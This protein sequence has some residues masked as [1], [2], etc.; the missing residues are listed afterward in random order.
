M[1][2]KTWCYAMITILLLGFVA[3]LVISYKNQIAMFLSS[4]VAP[5]GLLLHIIVW[6]L[7]ILVIGATILAMLYGASFVLKHHKTTEISDIGQ[8]GTVLVS[9][10]KHTIV[11][12]YTEKVKELKEKVQKQVEDMLP[13]PTLHDL[14]TSG[15]LLRM[16]TTCEMILGYNAD[17]ISEHT[18][19]IED[20]RTTG[21]AGKSRSGKTVTMAFLIIQY[22]LSGGKVYLID[23]AWNKASSL[24]RLLLP[25][26]ETGYIKVARKPNEIVALVDEFTT[27]LDN[28]ENDSTDMS[29]TCILVFDEWTSFM[30]DKLMVKKLVSIVHRIANESAG[31]N[32][33]ALVGGQNWQ[34]SQA[35]GNALINS[36]HSFFVHK[37]DELESKRILSRRYAKLTSTLKVG[38]NLFKDTSGDVI[39]LITP[40]TTVNDSTIAVSILQGKYYPSTRV[41]QQ[42]SSPFQYHPSFPV[43]N[44]KGIEAP[45]PDD[46]IPLAPLPP[47]MDIGAM[48]TANHPTTTLET[49]LDTKDTSPLTFDLIAPS[50]VHVTAKEQ[51]DIALAIQKAVT[52]GK[53]TKSGKVV[54][55]YVQS[56]LGY[57]NRQYEKVKFYCDRN[58]F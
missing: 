52:D 26:I 32:A 51:K 14:L 9:H 35:G 31:Y 2:F 3:Y 48:V 36:L 22:V 57:D 27:I 25:L 33:Y 10:G 12:P 13:V 43:Y 39:G 50:G 6:C 17:D 18:G 49:V 4:F 34:A 16:L 44:P 24:Y 40:L 45:K 46:T 47:L 5:L 19:T 30:H 38:Y 54:R 20:N 29:E 56:I 42:Y 37:I 58:G 7:I 1:R 55:T 53:L 15:Y 11:A 21:I 8:Y 23:K 41:Q 28:R